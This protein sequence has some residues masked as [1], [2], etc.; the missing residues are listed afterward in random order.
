MTDAMFWSYL[1]R[2][3]FGYGLKDDFGDWVI[4][5]KYSEEKCETIIAHKKYGIIARW[6]QNNPKSY[7]DAVVTANAEIIRMLIHSGI[8]KAIDFNISQTEQQ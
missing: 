1:I 3:F 6:T 8:Q 5:R 7:D 4:E 2:Y